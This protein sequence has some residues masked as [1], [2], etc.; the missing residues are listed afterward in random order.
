MVLAMD[1]VPV[2]APEK[3]LG[4]VIELESCRSQKREASRDVDIVHMS[5]IL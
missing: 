3:E 5:S 1:L 2:E 4:W